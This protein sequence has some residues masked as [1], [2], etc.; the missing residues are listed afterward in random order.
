MGYEPYTA[1]TAEEWIE[2]RDACVRTL[3][4]CGL[5]REDPAHE[6]QR[7]ADAL[8][9]SGFHELKQLEKAMR[10]DPDMSLRL[11][12]KKDFAGLVR[13]FNERRCH[14]DLIEDM[15]SV[16]E[17]ASSATVEEEGF[18]LS[19]MLDDGDDPTTPIE[20]YPSATP[21]MKLLKRVESRL[22]YIRPTSDRYY[23]ALHGGLEQEINREESGAYE[24]LGKLSKTA[25]LPP[26]SRKRNLAV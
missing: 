26:V 23:K 5:V 16:R 20:L 7:R 12:S 21:G 13:S 14:L 10:D 4:T 9:N 22:A 24:R 11:M 1:E 6:M 3:L 25:P 18:D 2:E 15:K 8:A 19:D 17:D